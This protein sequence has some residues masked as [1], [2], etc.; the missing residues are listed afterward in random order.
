MKYRVVGEK[1]GG[2]MLQVLHIS[3]HGIFVALVMTHPI[4][5]KIVE[6]SAMKF[7]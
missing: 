6:C 5:H 4:L 7:T 1:R 2:Q 3:D